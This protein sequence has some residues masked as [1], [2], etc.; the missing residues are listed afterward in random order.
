MNNSSWVTRIST[1]L[2]VLPD[3]VQEYEARLS[4]V[5]RHTAIGGQLERNMR[6]LPAH[7][8]QVFNDLQLIEA[9]LRILELK[10]RQQRS[11][12]F[13]KFLE[14]YNRALSSRDAERYVD[15]DDLVISMEQLVNELAY[16]RNRFLGVMKALESKNFMLSNIS[17]L[18]VAGLE[19][20]SL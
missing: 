4:D 17:K 9:V 1:D 14:S 19:D 2:A 15:G 5:R 13:K 6:E 7:T 16:L 18:R 12:V 20:A 8:E 3:F 11:Q 10:L